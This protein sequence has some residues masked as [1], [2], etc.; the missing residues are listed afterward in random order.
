MIYS[1]EAIADAV[2][3]ICA[4]TVHSMEEAQKAQIRHALAISGAVLTEP[5]AE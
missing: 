5:W 1:T 4:Q 3:Q 2:A